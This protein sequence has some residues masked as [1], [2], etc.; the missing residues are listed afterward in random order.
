MT[1]FFDRNISV[2]IARMLNHYDRENN[3]IHQDDDGRFEPDSEDVHIIKT[4][5]SETEKPHWMTADISQLKNPAERAALRDSGMTIF[6]CKKMAAVSRH[7]QSVKML[8]IWPQILERAATVKLPTA[9]EVPFGKI[10]GRL[11][12]K[13]TRLAHTAELFRGD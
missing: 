5:S 8:V 10:G 13:I 12:Q 7:H 11:N 2:H 9:F 6:F 3:I 1:F 4:L